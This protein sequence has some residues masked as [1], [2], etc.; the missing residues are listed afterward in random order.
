MGENSRIE[1][2]D[3]TFNPWLGCEKVSEACRNCYAQVDRIRWG[4]ADLWQGRRQRTSLS[5]WRRPLKWNAEAKIAGTRPRVFCAS[6]ADV[7]EDRRDLAPWRADLWLLIRDTPHLDWLLLTEWPEHI[8]SMLPDDWGQGYRNVWLGT[9]V[10]NDKRTDRVHHLLQVDAAIRFVSIEPMIS[11]IDLTHL[12][13]VVDD[14]GRDDT[15]HYNALSGAFRWE[16]GGEEGV[17]NALDWI[18]VAD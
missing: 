14:T 10:E 13:H 12:E 6:L 8:K 3:H 4:Q 1:W 9:T 16:G 17:G 11:N 7:F 15:L 18:M 2:C 5:I